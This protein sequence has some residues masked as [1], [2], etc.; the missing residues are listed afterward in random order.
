MRL[1]SITLCLFIV[2]GL[3]ADEKPK[4]PLAEARL[5]WLKG[6]Y[7]E[8]R[9]LYQAKLDD[10]KLRPAAAIGVARTFL[11]EGDYEKAL[12][13]L[14]TALK[15]A[16]SDADLLAARADVLYQTGQWD[17]ALKLA[18]AA[19]KE[20]PNHFAARWVRA[21]LLRDRGQMKEADQEMRWFVR[22]YTQ[23]SNND[24]DIKDPEELLLVGQAGC[25]NARWHHLHDQFRFI[26]NE[27]YVD[28][29][30][31][32]ADCWQAECLSGAILLE[33]FNRAQATKAFDNALK[34]NPRATE[35]YV[36]KGEAALQNYEIKDAEQF[37]GDA[38]KINPRLPA[39]LRL[40]A[41]IRIISGE[42]SLALKA[43][44]KA[45]QV[46]ARDEATLARV[47]LCKRLMKEPAE[48]DKIVADVLALNPKPALFYSDLA[49]GLEDR[50]MYVEA[51]KYFN[52]AIST[53]DQLA[54]PHSALGLLYLRIG[55]EKEAREILD[56]AFEYDKFNV[57]VA[58]SRK[59]LT[60]LEG[61]T[62]KET[63]HYIL[64][65]DA[66][67]DA[68]LA[69]YML[70]FLEEMHAQLAKDFNFEPE[71]KVLIEVFNNHE[72]FSGRT[73][74]L[75]DL[76]TIGAC[77]GRVVTMVSPA[78]KGLSKKFN[79]G[80][81]V[82]HEL[83]HIFNLAQTDFLVP[84]WLTEGLAVRNEGTGRPP[85]WNVTL[86]ERH[87]ANT[88]LTLDTVML[89]FVR[90]K[91]QEEWMLA[92]Y[93]SLLY[94]EYLIQEYGIV[95]V[96]KM[97]DAY[98]TGIDTSAAIKKVCG[99]EKATFEKAYQAYVTHI[100]KAIPASAKPA[101][102]SRTFA[103]LEKAYEKNPDDAD[104]AADLAAEYLRRKRPADARKLAEAVL[105]K[106]K[107][108][109]QASIV[110]AKLLIAAGDDAAAR[111]L[112]EAAVAEQPNDVRLRAFLGRLHFEGKQLAAAAEQF[113]RCQELAP[114]EA[115]W[116]E[117]LRSL[118]T[119][120]DDPDKLIRVLQQMVK[121]DADDLK[122]RV[123]LA[124]LLIEQ[125][126]YSE[127]E[128]AARDALFIDVLDPE[129]RKL[130]LQALR[131]QKKDD[132]ADRVLKRYDP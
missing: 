108:H 67:T 94:V 16:E 8:A 13:V 7:A 1:I 54:A 76:H 63:K 6:N 113:E 109:P 126:K 89:A 88:L 59:V 87:E 75:P 104:T 132:E 95:A 32:E 11:S 107:A 99:V 40:Q 44:E 29:V 50:K 122:S 23:R 77:T 93:Q 37:A 121:N 128:E 57:R 129:A 85:S 2:T 131:E 17:E 119:Q 4:G 25:E 111:K 56:K 15:K 115:D 101:G 52:L 58:N 79:W 46:N 120:I 73:V 105:A 45:L 68:V 61:Y 117:Q 65:F 118:Y 64:R 26:L 78:G 28:V 53:N 91:S 100:V 70:D 81:V 5:R 62:T 71:G 20:K 22:T 84:H 110:Q 102:K 123:Q 21:R 27:V 72:M 103:E 83:V 3:F 116:L 82:R 14:T 12:E 34:M 98:R 96:G 114:L 35:A 10:E 41:D 124:K 55:K 60:H 80:R 19:L 48:F 47:A 36:G 69:E 74:A 43:L 106:Q 33:K 127:A 112:V 130:F 49:Q 30:K 39:A 18:E 42:I 9:E 86:R 90:P 125:K 66:K 92:Y 51:E 31:F 38:L 24:D 97:L